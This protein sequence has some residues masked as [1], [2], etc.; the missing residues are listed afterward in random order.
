MLI[1][2]IIVLIIRK[3]LLQIMIEDAFDANNN[4]HKVNNDKG[5]YFNK[6]RFT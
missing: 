6:N 3:M 2:V 5:N 1:M 4:Y